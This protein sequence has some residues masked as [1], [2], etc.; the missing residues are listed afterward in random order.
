MS[1]IFMGELEL[2]RI[3][4][5]HPLIPTSGM[6]CEKHNATLPHA[7]PNSLHLR[8]RAVDLLWIPD[9]FKMLQLALKHFRGIGISK[10]F[11]HLDIGEHQKIWFY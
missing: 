10:S 5:D 1:S 8:G 6:R 11:L 2:Y 3:A 7:S 9:R 4:L